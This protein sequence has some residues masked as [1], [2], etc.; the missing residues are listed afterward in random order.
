MT[1]LPVQQH[2]P[3]VLL[4]GVGVSEIYALVEAGLRWMKGQGIKPEQMAR[5][6][7]YRDVLAAAHT[8]RMS[9]DG[10]KLGDYVVAERYSIRR[11]VAD[12]TTVANAA[13]E[14]GCSQRHVRRL[15][16]TGALRREPAFGLLIRSDV[17]TYKQQRERRH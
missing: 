4:Q 10:H 11:D 1:D 12:L 16:G 7:G 9:A 14:I 17:L 8:T 3:A 13:E 6:M 15:V 2:G 5:M